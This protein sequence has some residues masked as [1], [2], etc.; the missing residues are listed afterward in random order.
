MLASNIT[1][2]TW[3]RWCITMNRVVKGLGCMIIEGLG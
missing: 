1:V 2:G 3:G